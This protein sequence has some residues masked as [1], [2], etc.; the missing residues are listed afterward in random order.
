[1]SR[2]LL[3]VAVFIGAI[4]LYIRAPIQT[5]YFTQNHSF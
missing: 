4:L 2:K 3:H 1:M 5:G